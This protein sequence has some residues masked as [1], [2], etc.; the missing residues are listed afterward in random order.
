MKD[1]KNILMKNPLNFM[2]SIG[3]KTVNAV[4]HI[5]VAS[6]LMTPS[7]PRSEQSYGCSNTSEGREEWRQP[8]MSF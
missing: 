1:K 3:K 7:L 2:C 8:Q 5:S 4:N 6:H